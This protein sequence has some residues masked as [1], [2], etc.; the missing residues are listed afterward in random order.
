MGRKS[1]NQGFPYLEV[2]L[3]IQNAMTEHAD[4]ASQPR[5]FE[6]L[7]QI[8]EAPHAST[9]DQEK[10]PAPP[11]HQELQRNPLHLGPLPF[12]REFLLSAMLIRLAQPRHRAGIA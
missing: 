1:P 11:D 8:P 10:S 3:T 5:A 6:R 4:L 12:R 2:I 9:R 7:G